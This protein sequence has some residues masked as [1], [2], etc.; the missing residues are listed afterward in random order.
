MRNISFQ[1]FVTPIKI[2]RVSVLYEFEVTL[3]YGTYTRP[4]IH[5]GMRVNKPYDKPIKI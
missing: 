3:S 5:K 4:I 2:I 1:G